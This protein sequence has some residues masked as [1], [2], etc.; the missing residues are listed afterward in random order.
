MSGRNVQETVEEKVCR[1]GETNSRRREGVRGGI[2]VLLTAKR[3]GPTGK[4]YGLDMTDEMLALAR[5]NQ[6]K[7]RRRVTWNS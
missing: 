2:D 4:V 7:G 1:G 3:V 5:E 6:K